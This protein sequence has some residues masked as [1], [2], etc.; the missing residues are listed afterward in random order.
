MDDN[1][2]Y[3]FLVDFTQN[4]LIKSRF[5]FVN[6]QMLSHNKLPLFNFQ[7]N[8][9]KNI[10]DILIWN[11]NICPPQFNKGTFNSRWEYV[12][13]FSSEKD[14]M[15][16]SFPCTWRGQYPNVLD[17]ENNSRNEFAKDHK[18]GFPINLP[19]WVLGKMDFCKSVYDAFIG[20]GTTLIACEKTN[21]KCY[22]MELDPIYCDVIVKRY[23]D[24]CKN[25]DRPYSVKRKS[26]G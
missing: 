23:I 18:A 7:S 3:K 26:L 19:L 21:R 11:K 22:G 20:T 25:N 16:R 2:Y 15:S 4:S 13:C 14:A 10:K 12:F 1:D 6:I 17:V 5:V 8:F 9:H 24:Y